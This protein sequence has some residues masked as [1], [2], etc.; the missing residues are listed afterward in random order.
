VRAGLDLDRA[1][2]LASRPYRLEEL[3]L[4][5]VVLG[6]G[7]RMGGRADQILQ[8]M[9]DFMRDLSHA[10]HELNAITSET[11]MS[12]WVLG[13]LPLAVAAFMTL[14]SPA[15]FMPMFIQPLGHKILFMA[16]GLEAIGAFLLYRLAK[17]L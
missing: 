9:S 7:M 5:H 13:L 6:T 11:R 16:A 14:L 12:A 4:L 8:R 17:S 1:L 2:Q 10:R 15:F 3:E